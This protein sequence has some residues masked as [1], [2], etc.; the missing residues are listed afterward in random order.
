MLRQEESKGTSL[1]RFAFQLDLA[2][3]QA[4]DLAADRKPQARAAV[5]AARGSVGLLKSFEDKLLFIFGNSDTGIRHMKG[6]YR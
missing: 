3:E 2:A 6:Y 4:G 1:A 5:F